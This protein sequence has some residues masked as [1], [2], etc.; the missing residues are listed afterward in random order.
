MK[1]KKIINL[2]LQ[3]KPVFK[4]GDQW[5]QNTKFGGREIR[6]WTVIDGKGLFKCGAVIELHQLWG[7][8]PSGSIKPVELSL[9]ML[10]DNNK[11]MLAALTGEGIELLKKECGLRM[12]VELSQEIRKRELEKL[13]L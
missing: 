9:S 3:K 11:S 8:S 6:R 13:S 1:T 2:I 5:T 7:W 4:A 12:P 10:E